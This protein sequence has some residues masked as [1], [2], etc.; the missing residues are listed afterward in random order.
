MAGTFQMSITFLFAPNTIIRSAQMNNNFVIDVRDKYN[1]HDTAG[2]GVH[3]VVGHL[4][5]TTDAQNVSN[6][7]FLDDLIFKSGIAF[8]GILHHANTADRT[9]TFPNVS[10]NVPA[11]PTA[12]TTE[13]G[14]GAIVRQDNPTINGATLTGVII[15]PAGTTLNNPNIT[16]TVTGGA[17]YNDITLAGQPTISDFTNAQHNHQNAANGGKLD[18]GLA[19]NGLADDDHPQYSL[20]NGTRAFTGKVQGI[21][22]AGGDPG[23]TLATKDFVDSVTGGNAQAWALVRF[24]GTGGAHTFALVDGFNTTASS[25]AI[26]NFSV[27]F[28]TP[29]AN[30]DFGA[31][32]SFGLMTVPPA[33]FL[34]QSA[35]AVNSV[36]YQAQG[37]VNLGDNTAGNVREYIVAAYGDQ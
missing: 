17:T 16:G 14:T 20:S 30:T 31:L 27:G 7:T 28:P 26:T 35:K 12:A 19:L 6:K 25:S 4:L 18:H 33:I 1:A 9:Y 21:S 5:G 36:T 2:A 32:V 10:G 13:T 15:I 8:K 37:G 23:T 3:D 24:T 22:T 34:F 29:F 11:L